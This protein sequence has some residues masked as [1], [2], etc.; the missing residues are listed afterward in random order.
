MIVD[1]RVSE[2]DPTQMNEYAGV[3]DSQALTRHG[4]D[5]SLTAR[6]TEHLFPQSASGRAPDADPTAPLS[7]ALHRARARG[8][9]DQHGFLYV[10]IISNRASNSCPHAMQRMQ[11]DSTV[12]SSDRIPMP[13][14]SGQRARC[15]R[16]SSSVSY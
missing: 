14:Q 2:E 11:S 4:L 1:K 12:N 10:S 8:A 5:L 13:P 9:R 6:L 16:W 7:E 15:T 3:L